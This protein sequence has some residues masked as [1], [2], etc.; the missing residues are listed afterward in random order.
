MRHI[1]G[2]LVIAAFFAAMTCEGA[3]ECRASAAPRTTSVKK[4]KG[5]AGTS[6]S[7]KNSGKKKKS[8]GKRTETSRDVKRKEAATQK[9]IKDTQQ[10]I[11]VN[12]K[13]VASNL[14][15]LNELDLGIRNSRNR[16]SDLSAQV[17]GLDGDIDKLTAKIAA[18]EGNIE[19]LR[20]KYITA[21]KKMRSARKRTSIMGFIFS[22][23]NFYQAY[24]RIRYLRK[25]S[26]WRGR[27]VAHIRH[28]IARL[29]GTKK[30]LAATRK[31]KDLA[32]GQQQAAQQQLSQQQ[33]RQKETVAKLRADGEALRSHL[34]RKQAEANRLQSRMTELIAAEQAAA[35]EAKRR[36][37][38]QARIAAEQ[39]RKR[40]EAERLEAERRRAEQE[41]A[42]RLAQ[43]R[44]KEK[45]EKETAQ[46]SAKKKTEQPK[47]ET[48]KK[49]Q[50]KKETPAASKKK[51][52]DSRSYAEARNRRARGK[53]ATTS[54]GTSAS[55]S[56]SASGFADMKG[57]LPRPVSGSFA[58]INGFGPHPLPD[59]PEIMYDNPG[60]DA[61]VGKGES[62]KAVYAGTVSGVYM[63]NGFSNV[64]LVNHGDYFTVYGNIASPAVAKGQTVK[65][66]QSLGKLATD[67]DDDNRTTIHFE[68]WKGRTKLNPSEWIR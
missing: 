48:K 4:K 41:E 5:A 58:I 40:E 34:A 66:G 25:F 16:I 14:S 37:E 49:E 45:K 47:K 12:D 24:R 43:Q 9:E 1:F 21:V 13:E 67:P 65:Q 46:A 28:E 23:G 39:Q 57:K 44:E 32:L 27:Q 26:R 8:S 2:I 50:P 10:K 30:Q 64:V 68:V 20:Q 18:D 61:K 17:A 62:A 59:L 63:I 60:I 33:A 29:E 19:A 52:G 11:E 31:S 54:S 36:K 35:A 7:R 55:A 38:E 22:S 6:G 3:G 42:D 56:A 15:L 53:T 51:E